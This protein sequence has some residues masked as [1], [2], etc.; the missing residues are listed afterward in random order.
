VAR[1]LSRSLLGPATAWLGKKRLLISAP[2]SL[3]SVPIGVLPDPALEGDSP[4]PG[5]WPKPLFVDHEIVIIPSVSV[6]SAIRERASHR[7]SPKNLLAIFGD[8]VTSDRDDR[9]KGV[10]VGSQEM[11]KGKGPALLS[12]DFERL[13]HTQE[14]G[15][16]ILKEAGRRGVLGAFGF[17][18]TRKLVVSGQLSTYRNLHFATHGH[19]QSNDANR[20]ALILSMWDRNGQPLNGLLEATDIYNL[21]LHA[22]L[23]VLSACDTGLG[24]S[25]PGEGLVG[26]P[27]AFLGAG[28]TRVIVSLWPVEDLATSTLMKRF[29]HEYFANALPPS[30]AL[31]R[32]QIAMWKASDRNAPFYWGG[33]EIEGDW[34]W[35]R[36]PR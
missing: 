26:L 6:L 21:D 10:A 24:E 11:H 22:D 4:E 13:P 5:A 19:L 29:Y 30:E 15:D 9:L 25:I 20:S 17:D 3:Q 2:D 33:F 7:A 18:A 36:D 16:A 14:E 8:A 28:A 35:V 31:R 1:E 32:A 27:Q 34:Q 23:V 12:D